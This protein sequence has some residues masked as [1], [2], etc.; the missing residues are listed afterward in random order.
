MN[1]NEITQ[2]ESI[3]K[4]LYDLLNGKIPELINLGDQEVDEICQ[5]S[6][7][8]NRLV[9]EID[10]LRQSYSDLS[11]GKLSSPIT[12][13]LSFAHSLKNLQA[14][15]KHLTWQTNQIAQG[16]FTQH[17]DFL[18]EFSESFNWMVGQLKTNRDHLEELV[19]NRTQELSLLLSTSIQTSQTLDE[20]KIFRLIAKILVEAL[21]CHTYCRVIT[22]DKVKQTFQIKAAHSIRPLQCACPTD[23][24]YDL[25]SFSFLQKTID[26]TDLKVVDANSEDIDKNERDFFFLGFFQSLLIIPFVGDGDVKSFAMLNEAR[27]LERSNF[28]ID[29]YKTLSNHLSIS[30]HN[31]RLFEKN[32]NLFLHTIEALAA[33]IDQ[34]DAYTHYHSSNVTICAVAIAKSMGLTDKQISEINTAGLL[35]DIGK[36]GIRDNVL[37]KPGKLTNEEF[38]IIKSHPEKAVKILES[39]EDLKDIIPII[40]SHHERYDGKGYPDGLEGEEIHL[41]ARI[42][43]VADTFDAMTTKRVY[44]DAIDKKVS[45]EE[46]TR[47]SG[48]QFDPQ[49]V[50]AFLNIVYSL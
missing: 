17:I 25:D 6:Q 36:I 42:I 50:K 32:K 13:N 4:T 18:G 9:E 48:T 21:E 26:N 49:T 5:L 15:L 8:V 45:I 47:C 2:I 30:I 20:K 3:T 39:V 11:N 28:S 38:D 40:A 27:D 12:S 1:E 16:D 35:H 46:I 23:V 44:R 24:L 31:A 29:F 19:R 10:S 14:T 33:A 41:G 7:Y 34:R 37:L 22:I 43:A